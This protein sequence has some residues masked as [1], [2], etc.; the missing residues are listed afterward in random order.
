MTS[1]QFRSIAI[2]DI[3]VDRAA[4]QRKELV[5][6]DS[7]AQSIARRGLIHPIVVS[8]DL[9]LIAGERRYTACRQLG[10]THIP[11]QFEDSQ[12]PSALHE[13]ELEENIRRVDLPWQDR[14]NAVA[15]YHELRKAEDPN[16][17]Q[18]DTAAALGWKRNTVSDHISVAKALPENE[19]VAAAPEYSTARGI[20]TRAKERKAADEL[21]TIRA[22]KQDPQINPAALPPKP[23]EGPIINVDFLDWAPAY[24]GIPFNFGHFDFPYG[25][26]ADKFDQGAAKSHGGYADSE[27]LYW[28]LC[29]CLGKHKA[30]LFG[31]SAHLLFWFSMKHYAATLEFFQQHFWVDPYPLVW[32]KGNTGTLPDPNRGPRRVYEVAFWCSYG[33]RKIIRPVANTFLAEVPKSKTHMSE[34]AQP[35]LEHFFRMG[36]DKETR[37]LD[38]TAGSG[39]SLRAA[40]ALGAKEIVGLEI[41]PDYA[42]DANAEFLKG[43]LNAEEI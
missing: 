11:V 8:R 14:V 40:R 7:L 43:D 1:G 31:E 32:H 30:K 12:D 4:R 36:V 42:R 19:M 5:D 29:Q 13:V 2:T 26:N 3:T 23:T 22:P 20:V 38:P 28:R 27:E 6:V 25:I 15:R 37:F 17:T 9:V 34:K 24:T 10:W 35:M 18:D 33:D 16:W 21:A 41:N 39:S